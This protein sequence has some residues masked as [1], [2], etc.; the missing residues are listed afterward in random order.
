MLEERRAL[1]HENPSSYGG[2]SSEHQQEVS[3]TL[4]PTKA[5][6]YIYI[7]GLW[8]FSRRLQ[9]VAKCQHLIHI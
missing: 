1:G 4:A 3:K 6:I 8:Q 9:V 5:Y 2:V 7:C